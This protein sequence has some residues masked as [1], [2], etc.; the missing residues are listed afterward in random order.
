MRTYAEYLNTMTVKTLNSIAR[1][2]GLKG[3][4]KLRKAELVSLIDSEVSALVPVKILDVNN[5]AD[6]D[7]IAAIMATVAEPVF[8]DAT[9]SPVEVPKVATPVVSTLPQEE[10]SLEDLKAAYRHMRAS[11]RKAV[12][13]VQVKMGTRLRRL[14]A[15]IARY[16][17]K[18]ATL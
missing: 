4:S 18:A 9:E 15:E 10:T 13:P 16:G 7:A 3:Y 11:Y 6:L 14:S 5:E 2:M 1:D 12:G 17:I 8:S